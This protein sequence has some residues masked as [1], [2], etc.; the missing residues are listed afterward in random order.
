MVWDP[1]C[2]A[3]RLKVNSKFQSQ[4]NTPS[5][6]NTNGEG[7]KRARAG[8]K[9]KISL[10]CHLLM[11]RFGTQLSW[12][13][14]TISPTQLLRYFWHP[15]PITITEII[16]S[17]FDSFS[18]VNKV[19]FFKQGPFVLFNAIRL[20]LRFQEIPFWHTLAFPTVAVWKLFFPSCLRGI[21]VPSPFPTCPAKWASAHA[22]TPPRFLLR[23]ET[24]FSLAFPCPPSSFTFFRFSGKHVFPPADC[25]HYFVF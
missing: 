10:T 25:Y 1:L 14:D 4:M 17:C 22:P 6:E 9:E 3:K 19:L 21:I 7:R 16:C 8:V 23:K 12:P 18:N 24:L 15:V 5:G 13:P 2:V 11:A 20:R